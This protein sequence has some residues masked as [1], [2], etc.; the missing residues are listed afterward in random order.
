MTFAPKSKLKIIFT[1]DAEDDW[2]HYFLGF[3]PMLS[4]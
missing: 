2:V 1:P 4:F 3:L